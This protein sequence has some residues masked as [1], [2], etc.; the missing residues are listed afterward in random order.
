MHFGTIFRVL[1]ILLML[2]S[3]TML[4][5]LVVGLVVDDSTVDGFLIA[6]CITFSE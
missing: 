2:F 3:S 5:P 4:V 1:G 6:F